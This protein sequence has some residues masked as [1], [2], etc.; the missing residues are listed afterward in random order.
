M[1]N[2]LDGFSA[3]LKQLLLK[4]GWSQERMALQSGLNPHRTSD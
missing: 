2:P 1:R 4:R 3:N